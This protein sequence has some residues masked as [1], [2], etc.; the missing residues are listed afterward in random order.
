MDNFEFDLTDDFK[1]YNSSRDKT[2]LGAGWLVRGSKNVYK[3][4]S[5]TIASR[6]GLKRLGTADATVAGITSGD[7]WY[8]SKGLTRPWRVVAQTSAGNDGKMQVS[9]NDLWYDLQL[10]STLVNPCITL[11]RVVGESWWDNTEKKDRFVF[12]RGDSNTLHWSGG[13]CEVASGTVDTITKT[14]ITKTWF[15]D[16]FA[17]NTA[18]EK[19]II[20][21]G[22][23]YTY[24][25]GEGTS[26]LT[27]VT[28]D[29]SGL[30]AGSI[31]IQSVMIESNKPDTGFSSDF[32]KVV[33]NQ[34][35]HGSYTSR[36]VYVSSSTDFKNFTPTTPPISGDP[37]II[38]L[39][40][41]AKGIS[42]RK[43]EAHVSAGLSDWYIIS[44]SNLAIGTVSVRQTKRDKQKVA[45]LSA[46]L[47]HEF[48]DTVGDDIV[49]LSQD[50]QLRVFGTFRNLFQS[51]YPSLSL[52]VQDE[53]ESED[54]TGGHLKS[55]GDYIYI[56]APVSGRDY[57]HQTREMVDAA[58]NV[59]A[60]RLW[61]APQVRSLSRFTVIDGIIYGHSTANPQ[62]YQIWDTGQWSDDSPTD[63]PIPYACVAKFSY[64]H[65][66][67]K[68]GA[69]RQGKL[70]ANMLYTEGYISNGV[71][72]SG[73]VYWD[74]QGSSG[75]AN[76]NIN[77]VTDAA[78]F[79]GG[80]TG[81]SL[82]D[83][84]LG[85]N[86][87]GEGLTPE[88]ND[89]E[90]LNKFRDIAPLTPVD[91]FEY[92]IEF[93]STEADSRWELL[94]FGINAKVSEIQAVELRNV[95]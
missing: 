21:S 28:P 57:M 78:H 27:G 95:G 4:L 88:S 25:G 59:T 69:R 14:D 42:V 61:H 50:H 65:I 15:Q 3:K 23:E 2:N 64:G 54:F 17:N 1:G 45:N 44:F 11:S 52:A 5:G 86:P 48:I 37:L 33:G 58:G 8:T 31:A 80:Y 34:V 68:S 49:Y 19:K 6:P 41:N 83:S 93:Y 90:M 30:V 51:K 13:I 63:E 53:F 39:D 72:L 9:F 92:E 75:I 35:Y 36:F 38:T 73:N 55:I 71:G 77:S 87:L 12:V 47:A 84:S 46:A 91:C 29:A 7:T 16:G 60:E 89:Q 66:G 32:I 10:T 22:V 70:S 20:I 67:G 56:T 43:G 74:Y 62:I 18:G 76:V 94:S 40:D 81:G 26:T 79:Y 82:G 24:T 85:E